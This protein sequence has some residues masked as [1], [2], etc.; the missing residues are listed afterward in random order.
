MSRTMSPCQSSLC[1]MRPDT[2]SADHSHTA[3]RWEAGHRGCMLPA[4]HQ[5]NMQLDTLVGAASVAAVAQGNS[6]TAVFFPCV[7]MFR[8]QVPAL[9]CIWHREP[10]ARTCVPQSRQPRS[11]AARRM[12]IPSKL[13][14]SQAI[15]C[16]LLCTCMSA[17]HYG[18]ASDC[19]TWLHGQVHA[20]P[21]SPP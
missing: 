11:A 8:Q 7:I 15:A 6:N 3:Q 10:H 2:T 17:S 18:H 9:I 12:Q 13:S 20:R 1:T 14:Y 4:L 21:R 5:E 19:T 16:T